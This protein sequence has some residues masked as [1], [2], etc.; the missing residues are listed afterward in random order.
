MALGRIRSMS[1]TLPVFFCAT[2][3]ICA[4]LFENGRHTSESQK[5]VL[6]ST[7][8]NLPNAESDEGAFKALTIRCARLRWTPMSN[9]RF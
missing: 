6:R 3:Y 1:A 2:L 8:N 4:S 5:S 9:L 7:E